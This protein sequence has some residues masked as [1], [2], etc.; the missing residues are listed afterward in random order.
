MK[1]IIV[2]RRTHAFKNSTPFPFEIILNQE[3]G[4]ENEINA[5]I[6]PGD[7]YSISPSL[8]SFEIRFKRTDEYSEFTNALKLSA[9]IGHPTGEIEMKGLLSSVVLIRKV[10]KYDE[11]CYD[12][13]IQAPIIVR[14]CLPLKM[15]TIFTKT[16]MGPLFMD[17]GEEKYVFHHMLEKKKKGVVLE[18]EGFEMSEQMLY[19]NQDED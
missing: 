13:D 1:R 4:F 10:S 8:Y 12:W 9:L 7:F 18:I 3:S 5:T 2:F 16:E 15:S 14:N 17:R 11:E 6:M 19:F